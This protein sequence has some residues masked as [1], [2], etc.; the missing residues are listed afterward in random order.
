LALSIERMS[1]SSSSGR[2]YL[3]TPTMVSSPRSIIACR[4]AAVSSMRSLG[5]PEATAFV[6]P[7][8]PSISAMSSEA[9][10]ARSLVSFST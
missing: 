4:V 9:A 3:L 2:R 10:S 5:M 7:P 1:S 6:M 8:M